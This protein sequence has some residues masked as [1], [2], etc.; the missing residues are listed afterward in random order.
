MKLKRPYLGGRPY[1]PSFGLCGLLP[2]TA[3]L[4]L[5]LG[6]TVG[7]HYSKPSATVPAA[8]NYKE[9]PLNFQDAEGWKVA[10]PQ[11]A[12]L[13][14]NWWE[15][16]NQP[17]LNDLEAQLNISN[18]NIKVFFENYLAARA[19]IRQAR[20][21]YYPNVTIGASASRSHTA[22]TAS[23]GS[24]ATSGG[25]FSE[26]QLPL[27]ISWAPDLFGR[28]RNQVREFQ[29]NAQVSAAD[30]ENERLL[31]QATLAE[32]Y[33]QIR[34]QD[35]L[36]ELLNATVKADEEL[37]ELAKTRYEV[38]TD[39]EIS[40]QQSIQTL[41]SARASATNV[42][43]LRAQY[44]HAIATLLGKTATD[45]TIPVK[46]LLAQPPAIPTGTPSQLLER[47]PD[48]AAAE[49]QMA[50]ANAVIG[51]GYAAY[52]PTLTLSASGGFASSAIGKLLNASSRVWSVGPS[53]S[54]TIFDAGLR[55]AAIEQYVATYNA[56]VASYRQ[57]VLSAFQQ[58]EDYLAQ[59]RILWNEIQQEQ[60]A[61]SAAQKAYDLE[62]V[63]YETGLDPYL[64]LLTTQTA[65][66]GTQETLVQSQIQQMSS[67]VLLVEAL[68]GGWDA[69]QL[70]TMQ[71]V[72]QRPPQD[73]R[74]ITK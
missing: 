18:Q 74:S 25:T 26:F 13:H 63:R 5:T 30:L 9:S 32:T 72:T 47:R 12:M 15:I 45:F 52:Y 22:G 53:I 23:G 69:S 59:T 66:L 37:V 54:E 58:V 6:C 43:I 20:A 36:Q 14:G 40:V 56:D 8:P 21:Q 34:G 2:A 16:F 35:A 19:Q 39:T 29:A 7:P 1:K 31:E 46:P 11:D 42:G 3:V 61:V 62:K 57:T 49:R 17:E 71:Q 33:F 27:D 48:I 70:P 38:G 55:R 4:L 67:A 10:S 44:E 51:I 73:Q 28:V 68:G 64:N 41:E 50:S 60:A 65:L 24:G